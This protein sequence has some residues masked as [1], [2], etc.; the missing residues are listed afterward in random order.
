[1]DRMFVDEE[2]GDRKIL[3]KELDNM[4]SFPQDPCI[5]YLPTKLA[6]LWGFYVGKY[7]STMDPMGMR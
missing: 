3:K 4:F 7:S 5:V 1:M 2:V 6:H